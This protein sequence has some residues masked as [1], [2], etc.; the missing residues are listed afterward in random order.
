V[1]QDE[2]VAML[3]GKFPLAGRLGFFA[4]NDA[5]AVVPN[6]ASCARAIADTG[7]TLEYFQAGKH[8]LTLGSAAGRCDIVGLL[9]P[10][11]PADLGS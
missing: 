8:V 10:P 7:G 5:I 11:T 9:R 1:Y 3:R 2:E 4:G 6:D